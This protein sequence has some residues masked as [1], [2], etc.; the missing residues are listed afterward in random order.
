[1]NYV[2]WL[3]DQGIS[4]D[5]SLLTE[6]MALKLAV[7]VKNPGTPMIPVCRIVVHHSATASGNAA[8][9]RVLHRGVNYWNDIGYHF[10][11]G[12]GSLSEDGTVELGRAVPFKGAHARGANEDSLGIC[13]V[14][15]FNSVK[16]SRAQMD[17]LG[18]L[19]RSLMKEYSL[20]TSEITLHRL[21]QGSSTECPGRFITLPLIREII[22]S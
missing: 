15:N 3:K 11:I 4:F 10:V 14:G 6:S 9:F 2:Q 8:C 12:N 17:S 16:P 13:L 21:V 5:A 7:P 19:L 1:M 20:S 22:E 18:R